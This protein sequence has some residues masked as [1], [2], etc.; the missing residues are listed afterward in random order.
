ME[1]FVGGSFILFKCLFA[2]KSISVIIFVSV[3]KKLKIESYDESLFNL[4]IVLAFLLQ[5]E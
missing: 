2:C 3:G 4:R 5:D 1:F